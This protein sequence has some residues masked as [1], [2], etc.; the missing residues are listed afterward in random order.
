MSIAW[1]LSETLKRVGLSE[2]EPPAHLCR[3]FWARRTCSGRNCV[4][5]DTESGQHRDL[6]ASIAGT[7][8]EVSAKY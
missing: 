5:C 7:A 4:E 1:M 3:R 6:I 8:A 2:I